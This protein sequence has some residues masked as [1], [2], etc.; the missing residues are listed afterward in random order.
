MQQLS[1]TY[2]QY[3]FAISQILFFSLKVTGIRQSLF[4]GGVGLRVYLWF[5]AIKNILFF[6][7]WNRLSFVAIKKIK[8]KKNIYG[9]VGGQYILYICRYRVDLFI[10]I[11]SK[12]F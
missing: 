8:N 12:G 3:L 7:E 4:I 11:T 5:V 6:L 10:H 2:S 1:F 9:L